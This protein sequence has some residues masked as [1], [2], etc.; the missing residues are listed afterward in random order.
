MQ[1]KDKKEKLLVLGKSGSGKDF[2]VR[3]LTRM[4]LIP[5]LKTTTR[6]MR[7]YEIPGVTYDFVENRIFK[8]MVETDQFLCTQSFTVTPEGR[9][10]EV[11]H[12]GIT[13]EEFGRAQ[14]FIMTPAEFSGIDA[15]TRKGCFVV[16][17][18]IDRETRESR[19][20]NRNDRNDSVRRRLDADEVDFQG[21]SDY[22]L[23]VTDPEFTAQ[24]VYD[25][26]E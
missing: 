17:L 3:N 23:K 20:L 15:E 24:D 5:G 13:K 26:M 8:D 11:W 2:L 14:V 21:F 25:L 9:E 22:D 16:Y 4:G 6:P 1:P 12:Y 18:D 10:P 19:V 7:K